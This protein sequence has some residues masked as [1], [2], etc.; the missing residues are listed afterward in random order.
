V[1]ARASAAPGAAT[2]TT[3]APT[4][5]LAEVTATIRAGLEAADPPALAWL[6]PGERKRLVTFYGSGEFAP[7]WL[8][9][10]GQP[11]ADARAAL[12]LLAG[13]AAEG[14]HPAEYRA[15]DLVRAAERL[16][17]ERAGTGPAPTPGV[18]RQSTGFP[19]TSDVGAGS[20]P[21]RSASPSASDLAAFDADLSAATMRYY[22]QLHA[23]RVDPRAIGFKMTAPVD[24]HDFA[25]LLAAALAEHRVVEKAGELAPPLVLYRA[26]RRMLAR[27]RAVAANWAGSGLT[28]PAPVGATVRP[29]EP[30]ASTAELR[31]LLV[32]LGDLPAA[33][34]P[35]PAAVATPAAPTAAASPASAS[36]GASVGSLAAATPTAPS[37]APTPGSGVAPA[38][39]AVGAPPDAVPT[40]ATAAEAPAPAVYDG[41]LVEGVK[42]FQLRHGLTADGV[43]GKG[44]QA[45]LAVPLGWRVRQIELALER[46]RWAPHLDPSRFLAVNIPMYRLWVWNGI[47]SNGAPAWGMN[48]IVGRALDHS[49]P[50][51][52]EQMRTVVFRPYW[53]VPPSILRGEI[54]PALRRDAGYL[55]RQAM[56][57]VAGQGDDAP[58]LAF[59]PESIDLLA[60]GKLRVRQ[61]PGPRN[62]LGLLKFVFPND[63]NVYLHSTPSQALFS[64]S[65]RDFS[66]GCVRVEE[67]AKLAAWALEGQEGW[68]RE[69]VAAAVA[70]DRQV[71]VGLARPIQVVLF[72]VTA[73]VM[74]EDGTV[75]FAEDIYGHD[76]RLDRA[77]V[78]RAR[79]A[80]AASTA[81]ATLPTS[82]P[83]TAAP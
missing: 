27:Y 9:A 78:E 32:A 48:V 52:V 23:G 44:T 81:A 45:A 76:A 39:M 31:G 73:A 2:A 53:N 34:P 17:S 82:T 43:L 14:L 25:V 72:Y 80:A 22:Q 29:G 58:A 41:D 30:Y 13:A 49:T 33:A 68:T 63:D 71:R 24:E 6:T 56:E 40:A 21:A 12:S 19:G 79:V 11:S 77:L 4:F 61:R 16:A 83:A 50:V 57:V 62:A 65:R 7:R 26:L 75:H 74:P 20:A 60:R 59:G 18:D 3:P 28:L 55:D 10:A 15:A 5:P 35:S 46:L 8:D 69:R 37:P 42:R 47:P 51:F 54:L 67:P 1:E 64:R 66:H 38:P 70:G 36:V